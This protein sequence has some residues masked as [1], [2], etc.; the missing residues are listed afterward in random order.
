MSQYNHKYNTETFSFNSL[1][2]K[3]LCFIIGV[4]GA[5]TATAQSA[6]H[7]YIEA[8]APLAVEQMRIYKIPASITLAQGLLESGAGKSKL[9]VHANNHFGIK[10]GSSWTGP[11]VRHN[12]DLPNEQF[13]KYKS[14]RESYEDHSKFLRMGKRYAFLFNLKPDDYKGWA[15][16]LKKAGYA[17][18]PQY[19]H[20]L[21]QIIERYQLYRYDSDKWNLKGKG[22]VESACYTVYKCNKR[23]YIIAQAGDTY[24]SLAKTFGVNKRKL[25][26]YNEVGKS[27]QPKEGSIVYLQKKQKKAHKSYKGYM[28]VVQ[29]GESL[30]SISQMYGMRI[31]TLYELNELS[32]DYR[33]QVGARLRIR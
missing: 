29:N 3:F 8:Y 13:R 27:Q 20:A 24:E 6:Y 1:R 16:G 10:K 31:Q 12:D 22:S 25:R 19:A 28:H 2:R 4:L 30:H 5:F 18:N 17:T 14:V 15:H 9:A 21:I 26:K 23:Y 7:I 11:T 33:V 32:E